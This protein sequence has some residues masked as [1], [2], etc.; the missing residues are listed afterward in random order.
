MAA[1]QQDVAMTGGASK[2]R[3]HDTDTHQLC[4]SP[5]HTRHFNLIFSF[6]SL[7]SALCHLYRTQQEAVIMKH[8]DRQNMKVMH[9][10][11]RGKTRSG[12]AMCV[13]CENGRVASERMRAAAAGGE[14][15]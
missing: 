8:G 2:S 10:A 3:D 1:M 15:L 13:C 6:I 5:Q 14:S 9:R 4:P 7:T 11:N 12:W